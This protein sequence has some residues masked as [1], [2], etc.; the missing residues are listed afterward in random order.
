MSSLTGLPHVTKVREK[1]GKWVWSGKVREFNAKS[2]KIGKILF[3][4]PSVISIFKMS[5][6][7]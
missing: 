2:G 7:F 4:W 6:F 5:K 3:L 1:S